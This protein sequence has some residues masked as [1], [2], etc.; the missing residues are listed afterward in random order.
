[1][2][3]VNGHRFLGGVIGDCMTVDNFV[4]KVA[5][6]VGCV[7][8]ISKAATKSPQAAYTA[9]FSVNNESYISVEMLLSHCKMQFL[10]LSTK[11]HL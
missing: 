11:G 6:W 2:Q 3:I 10:K 1:M 9:P 4:G 7:E 5:V 8:K